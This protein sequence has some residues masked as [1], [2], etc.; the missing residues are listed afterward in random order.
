MFSRFNSKQWI[1]GKYFMLNKESTVIKKKSWLWFEQILIH[2]VCRQEDADAEEEQVEE[3]EEIP[4]GS[5]G[6]RSS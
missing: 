1:N 2:C 3:E 6:M 4:L 5:E